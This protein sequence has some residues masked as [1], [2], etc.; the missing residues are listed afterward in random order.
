MKIDYFATRQAAQA[1]PGEHHSQGRQDETGADRRGHH[2]GSE[3]SIESTRFHEIQEGSG[4]AVRG[5]AVALVRPT[6]C[7][8]GA[9]EQSAMPGRFKLSSTDRS[10][11][12]KC[13][14]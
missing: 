3:T 9:V 1:K 2:Q 10:G 7:L 12:E 4:I 5:A 8:R 6:L 13:C 11:C 14:L